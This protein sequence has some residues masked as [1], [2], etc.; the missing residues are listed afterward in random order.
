MTLDE[1]VKEMKEPL[2]SFVI[3]FVEDIYE[4]RGDEID[5][6]VITLLNM[7]K[8]RYIKDLPI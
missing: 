3:N 7:V 6:N 8:D 5:N 4:H 1:M 2:R